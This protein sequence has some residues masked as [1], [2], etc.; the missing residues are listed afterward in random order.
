MSGASCPKTLPSIGDILRAK[1]VVTHFQPILSARQKSIVG[2]EALSRGFV[3]GE[4]VIGAQALFRMAEEAGVTDG[5]E[6]LC[7]RQTVH[8]F[9]RVAA[10]AR[11]LMLFMNLHVPASHPPHA[12]ASELDALLDSSGLPAGNIA[13]EILEA[14]IQDMG[15]VR[16]LVDLLRTRGFLI[17]LDDVGSGYSNLDRIPY[18]KPDLLKVDRSLISRIDSDYHKRGT[19]KSLVDLG[20]KI[21]ALVVAEGVETED[22]AMVALELGADLLQGYYLGRPCEAE[23][24]EGEELVDAYRRVEALAKKFKRHMVEKINEQRL[25]HGRFGVV[26]Q[27]ILSELTRVQADEFDGILR[28][29]V[30]TYPIVE[31]LYVL[32]HSG[33]QV[34]DTVC[35]PSLPMRAHGGIFR[36]APRGADHSL[37]EYYYMLLDVELRKYTTEPYVS[38]ASGS[39]SRTISTYFRDG[40]NERMYILCVD[41]LCD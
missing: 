27:Q 31:C 29:A 8:S 35:N 40:Q 1:G 36:P 3:P 7:R 24:M 13:I 2:L 5:I 26:M 9:S 16:A 37:K 6:S 10:R 19:L 39:V 21:G 15:Q 33:V 4:G 23:S 28:R 11:D 14:E 18:I 32:D 38:L 25:Q 20:R 17:V 41:V 34:T 30:V 12:I 22:E